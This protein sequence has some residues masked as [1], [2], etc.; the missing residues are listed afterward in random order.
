ML[1]QSY[2]TAVFKGIKDHNLTITLLRLRIK[3]SDN[4]KCINMV[5]EIII[6][7]KDDLFTQNFFYKGSVLWYAA[8]NFR[9]ICFLRI[10]KPHFLSQDSLQI[11]VAN[12]QH[13]PL[14]CFAPAIAFCK[15]I[16]SIIYCLFSTLELAFFEVFH[17]VFHDQK[18]FRN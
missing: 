3:T 17:F 13:L 5:Y 14:T 12:S 4:D 9:S 6:K 15:I 7:N 2:L 16:K 11:L 1:L 10:K 18:T 8:N